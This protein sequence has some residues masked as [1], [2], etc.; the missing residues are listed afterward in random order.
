MEE[1]AMKKCQKK[2]LILGL[3]LAATILFPYLN[4]TTL[5]SS[6]QTPHTPSKTDET[7]IIQVQGEI[8]LSLP[9]N[10]KIT[11]VAALESSTPLIPTFF[12]VTQI[13]SNVNP[14]NK[15]ITEINFRN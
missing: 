12:I 11:M 1:K 14:N 5:P 7:S 4:G 10:N 15:K 3:T 2:M 9:E 6:S 8:G 13:I